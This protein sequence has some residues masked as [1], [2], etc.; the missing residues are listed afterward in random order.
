[1]QRGIDRNHVMPKQKIGM[2]SNELGLI[3]LIFV[4]Q[5]VILG[6]LALLWDGISWAM[7][8]GTSVFA[9]WLLL[10]IFDAVALYIVFEFGKNR[11]AVVAPMLIVWT[12]V[13][14]LF[15]YSLREAMYT[16]LQYGSLG[17]M[18]VWFSTQSFSVSLLYLCLCIVVTYALSF[19]NK[20]PAD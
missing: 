19:L 2:V 16:H 13:P 4:G 7:A 12:V 10:P 1:M 18:S 3:F 8:S 20:T 9:S 11:K 5:S 15:A 17:F 6:A 14:M